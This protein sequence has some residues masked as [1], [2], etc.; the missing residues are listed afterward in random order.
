MFKWKILNVKDRLLKKHM[1]KHPC[2]K[3]CTNLFKF[4]QQLNGLY[5]TEH[6][7]IA[8]SL[9]SIC[10]KSEFGPVPVF[11]VSMDRLLQHTKNKKIC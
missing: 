4:I 11:S 1:I 6:T 3:F 9:P 8:W 2:T 5:L 10:V 7:F